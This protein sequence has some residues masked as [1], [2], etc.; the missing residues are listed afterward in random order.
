MTGATASPA[1]AGRPG[2]PVRGAEGRVRG[3]VTCRAG[4]LLAAV[5]LLSSCAGGAGAGEGGGGGGPGGAGGALTELSGE[6]ILER[7]EA[8]LLEVSSVRTSAT[9]TG[10]LDAR[11]ELRVDAE[12]N[13][14]GHVSRAGMGRVD[15]ILRHAGDAAGE[16]WLKPDATAWGSGGSPDAAETY[17]DRYLHAAADRP[18]VAEFVDLCRMDRVSGIDQ[19]QLHSAE[20]EFFREEETVH[21]GVPVVRVRMEAVAE[22]ATVT[23]TVLVATEGEPYPLHVLSLQETGGM[24]FRMETELTDHNEPFDVPVPAADLTVSLEEL[25][26]GEFPL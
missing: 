13:C 23:T 9:G 7:A 6:E 14:A 2:G 22:S 12:G 26:P 15:I 17:A 4:V 8:A 11:L 21:R 24:S 10:G 19:D 18:E 25:A 20:R 1:G 3:G 5:L 16:V